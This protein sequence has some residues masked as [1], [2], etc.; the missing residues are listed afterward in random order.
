MRPGDPSAHARQGDGVAL[1]DFRAFF[2]FVARE[3]KIDGE[4]AAAVIERL[5]NSVMIRPLE[6]F[7][8]AERLYL[9]GHVRLYGM[10]ER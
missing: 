10:V 5:D 2:D 7:A 3:V 6:R 9:V 8:D 4:Q 1:F